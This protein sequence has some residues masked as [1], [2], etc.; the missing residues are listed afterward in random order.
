MKY[1][2]LMP[3][4]RLIIKCIVIPLIMLCSCLLLYSFYR[5]YNYNTDAIKEAEQSIIDSVWDELETIQ[6]NTNTHIHSTSFLQFTN[7]SKLTRITSAANTLADKLN[8]EF[9]YSN[10]VKGIILYNS[11]IDRYYTY[12]ANTSASVDFL[13]ISDEV[14]SVFFNTSDTRR[15]SSVYTIESNHTPYIL[16]V[17]NQRYGSI[18]VV[19]SPEDNSVYRS[20]NE[21]YENKLIFALS[22]DDER[23]MPPV[24]MSD[25][26]DISLSVI[27]TNGN[28]MQLIGYNMF[29]IIALCSIILLFLATIFAF[30]YLQRLLFEP[31]QHL[32]DSFSVIS[33][34]NTDYRITRSSDI[35]EINQFYHGFNDMLDALKNEKNERHRQQMDAVQAKLQYLQLQIRPHFYLN[36]LK[37]INSLAQMHEDEKIQTLVISLSDYF[38]YNF[39]D[40]KNFVTVR[41]ELEAVQSYVD[42]CRCL[43]NE[44]ELEFDI[45]S[46]VLGIKCLPLT[47]LTFVENAI[48]HG[49]DLSELVIKI[50]AGITINE[51]G[52]VY[53][54]IRIANTGHFDDNALTQLNDESPETVM[55]KKERVGISNVRYRMWLIYGERFS[56]TFKNKDNDAIVQLQFPEH[57]AGC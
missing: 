39:Q 14:L 30:N 45:D 37:N 2:H 7:S 55:Y 40:V 56:L 50:Y 26:Q 49:K 5:N 35:Y 21:L 10:S 18:A 34:G 4:S 27:Y 42:L 41:E 1:H 22:K 25:F 24:I 19:L 51:D 13:Q 6:A 29:Q 43:Y 54:N 11:Q 15:T 53:A 28:F 23:M 8:Q 20:F 33:S 38:R 48:K 17:V 12:F 9:S 52:E 44:I 32:S 3:R 46:E 57:F 16:Y 47:I 36:C 31:L